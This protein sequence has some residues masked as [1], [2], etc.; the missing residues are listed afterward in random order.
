[1]NQYG[2]RNYQLREMS[3]QLAVDFAAAHVSTLAYAEDVVEAARQFYGFLT[4]EE[5][6]SVTATAAA[7]SD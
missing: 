7:T 6:T 5:G 3:L 4:F 2:D 1:M